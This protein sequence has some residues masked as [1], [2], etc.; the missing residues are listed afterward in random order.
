MP[1]PQVQVLWSESGWR[2]VYHPGFAGQGRLEV[3]R[4][5]SLVSAEATPSGLA[6]TQR[7]EVL[8]H[9]VIRG[10]LVQES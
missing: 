8:R 5:E 6:A 1:N 4:G 7:G 9:R 2:C 3:Y 10:D